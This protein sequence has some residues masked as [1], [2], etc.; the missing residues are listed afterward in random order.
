MP[1]EELQWYRCDLC[2][3][4]LCH[5]CLEW[6]A[7]KIN[8][9]TTAV[10]DPVATTAHTSTAMADAVTRLGRLGDEKKQRDWFNKWAA[11][12]SATNAHWELFRG[13]SWV[14]FGRG[15][16]NWLSEASQSGEE[17]VEYV[18]TN[19]QEHLFDFRLMEQIILSSGRRRPMRQVIW[20][21]ELD[22]GWFLVEEDLA[23][24]LRA[25]ETCGKSS[26]QYSAR[27]MQYTID[28]AGMEQ[29]NENLGTRRKLR[30]M[31]VNETAPKMSRQ[32][33]RMALEDDFRDFGYRQWLALRW[34]WQELGDCSMDADG[35]IR[36]GLAE[37]IASGLEAIQHDIPQL[38]SLLQNMIWFNNV[39]LDKQEFLNQSQA[40]KQKTRRTNCEC[41]PESE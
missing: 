6:R 19:E 39:D 20:E 17:Q 29:V 23:Q 9:N 40:P 41:R 34:P 22:M 5:H 31:K 25:N 2:D 13:G 8:E 33:L 27:D 37:E 32:Q 18:A 24:R 28:I 1:A 14:P 15:L 11:K 36:T 3:F 16:S 4:D 38:G 35:F 21:V 30:K 12:N 26:F 7:Q 10:E